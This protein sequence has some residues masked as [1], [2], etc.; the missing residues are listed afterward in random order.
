MRMWVRGMIC[1]V[2]GI[3]FSTGIHAQLTANFSS[4]IVTGCS[5]IVVQFSDLSTG[6]PTSWNWNLGNGTISTLQNPSTI[7]IT[8]G[9]YNVSLTVT[10]ASGTDT[11][12]ITGYITVIPTPV[13][14]FY[15]SD[16]GYFCPPKTIQFTNTTV[17]GVGGA[18]TYLW[19]FGDGNSST[20]ANPTHTYNSVGNFNVTLSVTNASGCSKIYTKVGYMH[21]VA[22]PTAN[23]SA[24]NNNSCSLPLNVTFTNTSTGGSTY[25][26]LFGDGGTSTQASPS[27]VYTSSGSYTVTLI[28]TNS[29][30]C[31]DTIVK[32]A[33][34][35]I[36]SLT[37]SF[38]K[39]ASSAC[40]NNTIN[41]TN[42]STPGPGNSTWYFGDGTSFS[43][44]NAS[45][46]YSA[47]G[48]YTVKLVVHFNNCNDSTTQTVT[49]NQGP[50]TSF[51]A[52]PHLGC[53]VPFTTTFNNTTT[54][55]VSY[56]WFFGDGT[57]STATNP[58]H[59]YNALGQ[60]TVK[61]V[62]TGAN[63][64]NDTLILTN[65]IDVTIPTMGIS[66][67]TYNG[68]APATV[69]F[70]A[71]S[72]SPIPISNYTWDFGDGTVLSGSANMSHT[73]NTTGTYTVTVNFTTGPGCNYQSA[74]A[75]VH[76]GVVPN[77]SFTATP[78][79][80]CPDSV[81]HFINTSVNVGGTI[82]FWNFG[83]G[84][85]STAN[86]PNYNYGA[87]GTYTVTLIASNNGCTDSMVIPNMITVSLPKANFVG[88]V[89]CIDRKKVVFTD[90]SQGADHWLWDFGDGTTDTIQNPIH[91]YASY[92]PSVTVTL[93]VHNDSTGCNSTTN[94]SFALYDINPAFMVNDSI[95]CKGETVTFT[96]QQIQY[97]NNYSWDFGDGSPIQNTT[98]NSITH[99]YSTNGFY[100]V[101][102]ILKDDR[103]CYDTLIKPAYIQVNGPTVNFSGTPLFGCAPLLVNFADSSISDS[104]VV[105]KLWKFGDGA[106]SN[107]L[108]NIISHTYGP[109]VF[110]VFL[111]LV[112]TSGCKDSLTKTNYITAAKPIA[113]FYSLDTNSCPNQPV[114]FVNNSSGSQLTYTWD[115]GD[116]TTSTLTNPTHIYAASGAYTVSLIVVDSSSCRDTMTRLAY[117]HV[118]AIFISF[119]ASDTF[120]VCPPLTVNFTNNS[121]N[122][123][124]FTWDFGNG[125]VSSLTNPSVLYTQ[126]GVYVV[127]LTGTNSGGCVDTMSK[128]ITVLGPSGTFSYTP[129]SGCA[130]LTV[131]F[132]STNT[133]T[134]QLIWD[135]NNGATIST[136]NSSI[137][138]TYTQ[139][140]NF[141][142]ILLLSDGASCII[143]VVGLD[144]IKV[145]QVVEDFSHTGSQCVGS[146]I[147]FFD[148]TLASS[149]PIVTRNWDF[150]DGGT[151]TQH[152]PTH[153]YTSA[154]T[155]TVTLIVA[156]AWGCIDT[157][158]KSI[159]I[160][161]IPNVTASPNQFICQG[162]TTTAQLQA[163]GAVNY[164]W[165]PSATLS[166]N[167]CNNPI[168]TPTATTTYIVT[169]T[170]V[171]GCADTGQVTVTIVPP[172]TIQTGANPTICNGAT[173]Q[174]GASGAST[175]V[176]SPATGLSCTACT[177]PFASPSTT[178]TYTVTGT[179]TLGCINSAQ[180]TVNV[181]NNPNVIATTNKPS[182]CHGDSSLL[183]ASGATTY[184]WS[185]T[186]GLSCS[187][188]ANPT[189]TPT[190]TT[191]YIVTGETGIC[192]D[193]GVVTIVVNPLPNVSAGNNQNICL[194]SIAQLQ[195]TGA[196]NYVWSPASGLS[197]TGCPNPTATLNTSAT[198]TV[199]GTDTNGCISSSQMNIT[200]H[201]LPVIS[202]SNNQTI[203]LGSPV[204]LLASGTQSYSWSPASGLSC[205]NCPNPTANPAS[206]TTYTIIGT[207]AN[208]CHDTDQV[209]V[210]VNPLPVVNAGPDTSICKLGTVQLHASG[211]NSYIW[212][213]SASL[214]C[215][216]C[217][218]PIANPT[219]NTTY[220]LT[221]TDTNGCVNTDNIV[222]SIYPQ[223]VINAGA[224]ETICNGKSVQL[225][226]SG[227]QTYIWSP[228]NNL[229]CNNC[230]DPIASPTSDII[231]TVVGTDIN[232]CH[233]SD[234]VN[235][236][237]IQ[238]QPFT[239]GKG[240]TLCQGESA[241]LYVSGGDTYTWSPSTGL[242]NPNISNPTAT[243]NATTTYQIIIKQ[244][245]CF[246]DTANVT[247]VVNPNPTV[248]AGQDQHVLSGSSVNLLTTTTHTTQYLWSP[249]TYLSCDNC[250]SPIATPK[251]TITYTVFVS[252]QYGCKAQDDVT[253]F[254]S[255]DQSLLFLPNTFTPNG[256]GNNDR[257]Y[258]QGKGI[259]N[260]N[261]FRIYN[262]WGE[263][264]FEEQNFP[265]NDVS[266]GWDGTYKGEPLKPDVFVYI[267]DTKCENGEPIQLKGDIS[268]IR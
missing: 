242:D 50:S 265:A 235:V 141:V 236:T 174:L 28:A 54:G 115:F 248:Y 150:G 122:T 168:A 84:N 69:A 170:T 12:T 158:T 226:A 72:A 180:V 88:A 165:T 153:T 58:T 55:A 161:A 99:T 148:T 38:T 155:Y 176:W 127:T 74:A 211:A 167:N 123:S 245:L 5:P 52:S 233:D 149:T 111:K 24:T 105:S 37:A 20:L 75:T 224:D 227:G 192:S 106:V 162:Q 207:D 113:S 222:V 188:C 134:Q 23:F 225:Q 2:I 138:Y 44:I 178:T 124:N 42:T 41:F 250:S 21:A 63:G 32:P 160:E 249:S 201:P 267:I 266:Y 86:S 212:S 46:A 257:F 196:S 247:V 48:T 91:T 35:N 195:A 71:N 66:P 183:Q 256:D 98:T 234:K 114:S 97:I 216:T 200:V 264:L 108:S 121:T 191:T 7:Y 237:V 57:T 129:L 232:G 182:I 172:P 27:H 190:N 156:T 151:S 118:G 179:T 70:T 171:N 159:L 186:T 67:L 128:T 62:A 89:S 16:S 83:N 116:G 8:P 215:N 90:L 152:N 213:P 253:L 260:I 146:P 132:T 10:N 6:N 228:N 241:Q 219:S 254:V 137:T 193:T 238:M 3:V 244:G 130:P 68:C 17:L 15:A 40:T 144:T 252:N 199:V 25:T 36:G 80:V 33:Y 198:Y 109:G 261:R 169:G 14:S 240:D 11:K 243:P 77:A 136:T 39:S 206:S 139:P 175:Y 209:S 22:K 221:G 263:L 56:L 76:L 187:T 239:I 79:V 246:S 1:L 64:C 120:A 73:Y 189:A 133:N 49:I 194:G 65:Y 143:P 166:C 197:C 223:P 203:C 119:T 94:L 181:T 81:V 163:F 154:G 96:A 51:S 185:P 103:N 220:T 100:N 47:P 147:S 78:T 262:R 177:S 93:T 92:T 204:Q 53:T 231:Y 43:G 157:V 142:P 126:P 60:Y 18:A 101:R 61:L 164:S 145:N 255:C 117:I 135:F 29:T 131:S 45:H 82:Y 210:T 30:G 59:T 217:I 208:G 107:S 205:N 110:T 4:N 87:A 218:N 19:D 258:P 140:G 34:V 102:L 214:S 268:L 31:S 173:V 104:T 184:T 230:P 202:V 26:W 259:S 9:T 125:N 95:I 251:Q 112:D 229:S 85:G 13:I